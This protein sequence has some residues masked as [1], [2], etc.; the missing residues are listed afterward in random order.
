MGKNTLNK[1]SAGKTP[2]KYGKIILN[3]VSLF[4]E[5]FGT[6]YRII[7]F[8]FDI[9]CIGSFLFI[10]EDREEKIEYRK[11]A[12][13]AYIAYSVCSALNSFVVSNVVIA[14]LLLAA[15]IALFILLGIT[16]R[17]RYIIERVGT[18]SEK[19]K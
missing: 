8:I 12:I 7:E 3:I 11:W 16:K 6:G 17:N 4:S 14:L 9:L 15:H 19:V 13:A 10:F 5:N 1:T 2:G 18:Y